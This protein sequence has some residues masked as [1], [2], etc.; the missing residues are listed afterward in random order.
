[1]SR[2]NILIVEDSQALACTYTQYLRP[3]GWPIVAVETGGAALELIARQVP[4]V[5]LLDLGLPDM[6]GM[7]IL[8]R[9]S[10]R[11]IPTKIVVVTA[12][13][14]LQV[15]VEAMKFGAHDYLV[16]PFTADRLLVTVRNALDSGRLEEIVTTYREQID[17]RNYHGFIGSS[18]VMQAVYRIIDA[19]ASSTAPVFITGE[20]GT[21]K[22]VC[23]DA[24]HR[25]GSRRDRPFVALNCAAIPHDLIESEIFGHVKGAFT[26]ATADRQ[27][28]AA[29]AKGGT[30]FLDEIC[31]MNIN[32]QSKLLRLIQTGSFQKVGGVKLEEADVRFIAATNRDP[33]EEVRA[34]RFREDLFYRLHVIPILMPPLREREGDTLE[35]AEVFL[36]RYSREEHKRFESV[37]GAAREILAGY[38]WP[39]NVRQ[40]ANVIRNIV[41]LH[42]APEIR[43]EM[44]PPLPGAGASSALQPVLPFR[45]LST[46]DTVLKG[47][48][49]RALWKQ[50]REIIEKAIALCEGN[51]PR[52]AAFLEVS[53]S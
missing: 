47:D 26:G 28:A 31:E 32:L 38:S 36:E 49:L 52:A 6:D 35:L 45:Q 37:S 27:G 16:K 29:Q 3:G 22:E 25:Q 20:S 19:A 1:M 8:R 21:G 34:G 5:M 7:D 9:V 46:R 41:V 13:G 42:D 48:V 10:E 18:L 14:S 23:A 4:S 33:L 43:P 15:A 44:L 30:L 53:P 50:E 39:G 51:V 17:R 40:L 2:P 12:T 24:I 11:K